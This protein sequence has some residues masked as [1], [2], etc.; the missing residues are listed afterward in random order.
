MKKEVVT[1]IEQTVQAVLL[2]AG[3]S[4]RFNTGSSK[5]IE[6]MCGREII[7]YATTLMEELEL[8]TTIVLGHHAQEIKEVIEKHHVSMN[9]FTYAYQKEQKGTGNALLSS[10]DLWQKDHILVLNGDTP[11]VTKEIIQQ[12]I[13]K[14]VQTNASVSFAMAH[15][16]DSS[17]TGYGRIIKEGERIKIIETKNYHGNL[18]DHCCVNAGI[19]LFKKSFLEKHSESLVVNPE[20]GE[21]YIT[22][23]IEIASNHG[24]HIE[25]VSVNFDYVRGINTL[26]D[27]WAAEQIKKAELLTYW[28]NQGVR[29]YAPQ[30]VHIDI[31]ISLG[32]GT[33]VGLGAHILKGTTVGKNCT[34][35]AFTILNKATLGNHVNIRSHSV[36]ESSRIESES[37][38]GP[39]AHIHTESAINTES[40]IGNFVEI[41]KSS[42]GNNSKVK[43]LSYLGDTIAGENVNIGAGTITCNHNGTTKNKTYIENNAYIGSHNTLVAP[44]SI[45]VNAFTAA[46]SV[47]TKDVPADALAIARSLQ[48]NK[49]GYAL[50]LKSKTT[51][52]VFNNE[53]QSELS[54]LGALKTYNDTINGIE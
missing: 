26:K 18:N 39:F 47:L 19:Y 42:I 54:F 38:I 13:A 40:I 15:N 34:I 29:F 43:H 24:N 22:D 12:F 36:I 7:L 27:L 2:A 14:H 28:M 49:E 5:L 53:P 11:L 8:P 48:T 33:V 9:G 51:Q 10:K 45:G 3:K 20:S 44:L 32:S 25:T 37:K 1:M 23:L 21:Y 30:T 31:D 16:E 46:G 4:S 50:R 35:E 41:K 6:K 17:I 52:E